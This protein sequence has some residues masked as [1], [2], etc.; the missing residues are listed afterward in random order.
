MDLAH[1]VKTIVF[2][3]SIEKGK[4]QWIKSKNKR[5]HNHQSH[6]KNQKARWPKGFNPIWPRS[7]ELRPFFYL[8]AFK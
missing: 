8:A 2:I 3:I 5:F 6:Q 4:E 7:N 1:T